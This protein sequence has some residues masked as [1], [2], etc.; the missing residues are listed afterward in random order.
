MEKHAPAIVEKGARAFGISTDDP[1]TNRR[2]AA[3]LEIGYPILSD[4]DGSVG[5]AYGVIGRTGFAS[6]WTFYIAADGRI[7]AIDRSVKA[8]SHGRDIAARLAEL[9]LGVP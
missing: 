7:A 5:R 2:F 4:A 3:S 1:G 6:R 9:G 8:G